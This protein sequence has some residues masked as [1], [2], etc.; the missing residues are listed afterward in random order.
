MYKNITKEKEEIIRR[1]K[2]NFSLVNF[3]LIWEDFEPPCVFYPDIHI[4]LIGEVLQLR[5]F[6]YAV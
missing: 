3:N 4:P 1:K 5:V 6:Y 2:I